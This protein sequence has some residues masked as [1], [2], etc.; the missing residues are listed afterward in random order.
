MSLS[1]NYPHQLISHAGFSH[2]CYISC[3][4]L[5]YTS[6]DTLYLF[7]SSSSKM[8]VV[9]CT[10]TVCCC[11]T[12]IFCSYDPVGLFSSPDSPQGA[13]ICNITSSKLGHPSP[14]SHTK[15]WS[16]LIFLQDGEIHLL[17]FYTLCLVGVTP[18]VRTT[19]TMPASVVV[20]QPRP[21][22]ILPAY[23]TDISSTVSCPFCQQV[24]SSKVKYVPGRTAWCMC[25]ILALSGWG[26]ERGTHNRWWG[27]KVTNVDVSSVCFRLFFGI[28]LIPF[29]VHSL[30][31]VH[32]YCPQ[33]KRLLHVHKRWPHPSSPVRHPQH[34]RVKS[35]I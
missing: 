5:D 19:Q 15:Y 4:Y 12:F 16:S 14:S 13:N 1:N 24:V 18:P 20:T 7:A 21:I 3:K 22:P 28:C 10:Y 23:L 26:F 35:E 32:H 25:V 2:H 33:C 27:V 8:L 29:M 9:W 17:Y 31:D 34:H 30:H 11:L 6:I